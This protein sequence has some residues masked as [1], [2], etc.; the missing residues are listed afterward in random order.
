MSGQSG[1]DPASMQMPKE[2]QAQTNSVFR[3][4]E[5]VADAA[6]QGSAVES[7]VRM[8]VYLTDLAHFER[9]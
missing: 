6:A 2:S 4:L 7:D 3:N 5:A 9:L 1:L 8:T